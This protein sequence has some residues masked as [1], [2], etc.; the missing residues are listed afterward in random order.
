MDVTKPDLR[1]MERMA[2]AYAAD[3]TGTQ[4]RRMTFALKAGDILLRD[5]PNAKPDENIKFFIEIAIDEPGICDREPLS[6][7]LGTSISKV[8]STIKRFDGM[9]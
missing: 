1:T 9:Y 7:V 3:M 4:T 8:R 2:R 6:A 5:F